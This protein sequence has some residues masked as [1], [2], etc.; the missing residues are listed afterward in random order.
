MPI[1]NEDP[2]DQRHRASCAPITG[3]HGG[4]GRCAGV[5]RAACPRTG[6]SG[7]IVCIIHDGQI[8]PLVSDHAIDVTVVAAVTE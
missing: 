4:G 3:C 1:P 6:N 7:C 2:W 5:P 8:I